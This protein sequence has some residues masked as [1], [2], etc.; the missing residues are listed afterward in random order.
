MNFAFQALALSLAIVSAAA[1]DRSTQKQF[2]STPG[3]TFSLGHRGE[4]PRTL[5]HP[6]S[7]DSI[8]VIVELVA[9][10]LASR[11]LSE[12]AVGD[13]RA[14]LRQLATDL[15]ALD[16]EMPLRKGAASRIEHEY[17]RV[18]S[19]AAVTIDPLQLDSLRALPY[20]KRVSPDVSVRA[21][22]EPGVA[23]VGADRV[24]ADLDSRGAGVTVAIVDS[25]IDYRHES[26]GGGFGPQFKVAGG[27]DF[28]NDDADPLDD[29]G[30]GTH[31]A[32][33]VA[34]SSEQLLGVA[35]D[36]TLLAFKVLDEFGTG[37][38]SSILAALER[39]ADPNADGDLS[40][41][42]GVANLSLGATGTAD[43]PLSL[44][45]DGAARSG[46][47]VCVAAG[48][49]G[50]WQ[51][52]GSPGTARLAFTVGAAD[53]SGTMAQFSSRGPS[54]GLYGFKPD[55]VAPGVGIRSTFPDG[56]FGSLSGTSMATPHVAGVAA[57]LRALHPTWSAEAIRS[58]I[59]TTARRL[60]TAPMTAGSGFVDAFRAASGS[61]IAMPSSLG[62][63]PV[64]LASPNWSATSRI[65][66]TNTSALATD[67]A[68]TVVGNRPGVAV[69][70]TSATLAVPPGETRSVGV[71]VAVDNAVLPFPGDGS[72]SW[73]GEIII[74][75]AGERLEIP[76]AVVK[77]CRIRA[78]YDDDAVV[79]PF[80]LGADGSTRYIPALDD[81][82]FE[83]LAGPGRYDVTLFAMSRNGAPNRLVVFE[84]REV[85][86]DLAVAASPAS[87]TMTVSFD[88]RDERGD[89][90]PP[91]G[92]L[93]GGC[94]WGRT[95]L[96]PGGSWISTILASSPDIRVSPL[97]PRFPI[98]AN[99]VCT[100]ANGTPL[101]SMEYEPVRGV[102]T[103]LLRSAGGAELASRPLDVR[104]VAGFEGAR[105]L[106]LSST[107]HTDGAPFNFSVGLSIPLEDARW[108]GTLFVGPSLDAENHYAY[109]PRV[110][111]ATYDLTRG[112]G[113]I[114]RHAIA[115][116]TRPDEPLLIG[117]GRVI[118]RLTFVGAESVLVQVEYRDEVDS[119]VMPVASG[120][121][122]FDEAGAVIGS[123]NF[124][125]ALP[126]GPARSRVEAWAETRAVAGH[127]SKTS[128]S[129]TF[130]ASEVDP[131]PPTLTSFIVLDD[132]G[133]RLIDRTTRASA[134]T[135]RVSAIDVLEAPANAALRFRSEPDGAWKPIELSQVGVDVDADAG[136]PP[137]GTIWEA[138][139]LD[140]TAEDG[141]YD[142]EIVVSDAAGNSTTARIEPAI[143]VGPARSRP[144]RR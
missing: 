82:N 47:V 1:V 136:H 90:F 25:G 36:A 80:L 50:E 142:L 19:G 133:K 74:D 28:V 89:P 61:T 3:A 33:I 6:A 40:D 140:V 21:S 31:V 17:F 11:T 75:G 43:D 46:I 128:V 26:L 79:I 73:G 103:S 114:S 137:A 144:V 16:A 37:M 95:F 118:P 65:E 131:Y 109:F 78:S 35:P 66:I 111:G 112:V 122:L 127:R 91:P 99:E 84:D 44:A 71:S 52:I 105:E 45:V 125:V 15:R 53:A 70:V 92:T 132:L 126:P 81:R 57:L 58:R 22:I 116:E 23:A 12:P 2:A 134:P 69:S 63:G 10:P 20:V 94:S 54:P 83:T 106:S 5:A 96:L 139:L 39:C 102:A 107:L 67:Y 72:S 123:G 51:S 55:V 48:N 68:F 76:W 38:S 64:D 62:F 129:A 135:L 117:A 59:A 4:Q 49:D 13:P 9:P 115:Y 8:R 121:T 119:L 42:V 108:T 93:A 88:A 24:W 18:F 101:Y 130:G 27:Y 14:M 113:T 41:H 34:A 97:S 85:A 98:L 29:N 143:A 30:H 141:L 110:G 77:G 87:A 138:K 60:E 120:M 32:G 100:G 124:E 104:L 86:T 7:K 56:T